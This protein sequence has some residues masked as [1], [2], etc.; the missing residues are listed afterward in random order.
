[1]TTIYFFNTQ[2]GEYLSEGIAHPSPLEKGKPLV[3][4]NARR[5]KP[6]K[7]KKGFACVLKNFTL[8][9]DES[10]DWVYIEDHRGET[11]YSTKAETLGMEVKVDKLGPLAEAAPDTTEKPMPVEAPEGQRVIWA[12]T[13][14]GFAPLTPEQQ[15]AVIKTR[16]S[17]IDW[18][19]VRALRAIAAGDAVQADLEKLEELTSEASALREQLVCLSG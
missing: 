9:V 12:E 10:G 8:G 13:D 2:T 4:V 6:L 18:I 3:P 17:E 5:K 19:S 15:T 16:L 7:E 11:R 1:M 14:W